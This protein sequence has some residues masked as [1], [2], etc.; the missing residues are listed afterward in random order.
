[1]HSNRQHYKQLVFLL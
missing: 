1:M